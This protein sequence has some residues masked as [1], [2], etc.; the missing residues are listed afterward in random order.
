MFSCVKLRSRVMR[1]P[2][3][4]PPS[5]RRLAS[6]AGLQQPWL[7]GGSVMPSA[8]RWNENFVTVG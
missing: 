2:V 4:P 5:I 3:F 6:V 8:K 7:F 1:R